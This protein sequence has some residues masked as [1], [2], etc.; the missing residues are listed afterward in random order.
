MD[1]VHEDDKFIPSQKD[2]LMTSQRLYEEH[3]KQYK[4]SV[5]LMSVVAIGR[6]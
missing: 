4:V 1:E 6:T 3:Q 2:A 5:E